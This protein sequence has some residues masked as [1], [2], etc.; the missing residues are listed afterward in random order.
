MLGSPRLKV[1]RFVAAAGVEYTLPPSSSAAL[2]SAAGEGASSGAS[3]E[4]A[5][6]LL[7][8]LDA[9]AVLWAALSGKHRVQAT[10]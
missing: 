3:L 1:T 9:T 6:G 2:L 8:G 5:W 7:P 4:E 10:A